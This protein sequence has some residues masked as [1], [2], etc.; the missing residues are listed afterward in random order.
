MKN[1]AGN[2]R[3]VLMKK[4]VASSEMTLP[5]P[6]TAAANAGDLS[7][8]RKTWQNSTFSAFQHFFSF[9]HENSHC[10]IHESNIG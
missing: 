3:E 2:F 8:K 4:M 10:G 7:E 6:E 1:M 9:F 5:L